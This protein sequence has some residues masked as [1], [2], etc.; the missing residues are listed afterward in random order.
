MQ[1]H[2]ISLIFCIHVYILKL[3]CRYIERCKHITTIIYVRNN[4]T[5][6]IRL[7]IVLKGLILRT[8]KTHKKKSP[9]TSSPEL[10]SP[11]SWGIQNLPQQCYIW[12]Q[13]HKVQTIQHYLEILQQLLKIEQRHHLPSHDFQWSILFGWHPLLPTQARNNRTDNRQDPPGTK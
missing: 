5:N 10:V 13:V 2:A 6:K 9:S 1:F 8:Q 4:M 7:Q 12:W 11:F 3:Y